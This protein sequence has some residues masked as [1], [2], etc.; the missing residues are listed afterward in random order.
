[1]KL[2]RT[3]Y[4]EELVWYFAEPILNAKVNFNVGVHAI[5]CMNAYIKIYFCI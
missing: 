2:Q 3:T 5:Y 1:M 4:S